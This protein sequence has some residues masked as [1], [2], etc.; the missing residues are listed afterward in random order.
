MR[1]YNAQ[2]YHNFA[3]PKQKNIYLWRHYLRITKLIQY[4]QLLQH[5]KFQSV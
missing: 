5:Q 1:K 2:I 3:A 4:E